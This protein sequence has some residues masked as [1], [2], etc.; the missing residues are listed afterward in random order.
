[1]FSRLSELPTNVD[2]YQRQ[3]LHLGKNI[4]SDGIPNIRSGARGSM[5]HVQELLY[6]HFAQK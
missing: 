1:M 4:P 3:Y 5:R 2:T 6:R